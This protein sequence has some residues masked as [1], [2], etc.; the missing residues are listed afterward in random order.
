MD[1]SIKPDEVGDLRDVGHRIEV[2]ERSESRT[3]ALR[4]QIA[5]GQGAKFLLDLPVAL[6]LREI[7]LLAACVARPA[8][9]AFEKHRDTRAMLHGDALICL[10]EF[11]IS[12]HFDFR[13]ERTQLGTPQPLVSERHGRYAL[14]DEC[15][16][17]DVRDAVIGC[18]A[19]VGVPM[20]LSGA[21]AN[22]RSVVDFDGYIF[23]L[24]R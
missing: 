22:L 19:R 14:V 11:F 10:S 8:L 12:G 4:T 15:R 7:T 5:F 3:G 13:Q 24:G 21:H 9:A 2:P 20:V 16:G 23:D 17:D 6:A 1:S 18:L